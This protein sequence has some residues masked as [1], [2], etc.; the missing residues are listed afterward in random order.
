MTKPTGGEV[1]EPYAN[2]ELLAPGSVTRPDHIRPQDWERMGWHARWK[3][4]RDD[5]PEPDWLHAAHNTLE[6]MRITAATRARR[7]S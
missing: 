7:A 6:N 2:P 1:I 4:T 3:A 5:V